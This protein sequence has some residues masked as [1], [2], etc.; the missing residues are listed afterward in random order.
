MPEP[1]ATVQVGLSRGFAY[2]EYET[3]AEADEAKAH[4][5]GGQ[6]D[7]NYVTCVPQLLQLALESTN[8][9][10]AIVYVTT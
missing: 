9:Q 8:L 5:D 2:V 6:I 1:L 3:R 7:G 4:M 10:L